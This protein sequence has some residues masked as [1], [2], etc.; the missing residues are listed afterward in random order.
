MS[1]ILVVVRS[2]RF[3]PLEPTYEKFADL[4][5]AAASCPNANGPTFH[6]YLYAFSIDEGAYVNVDHSSYEALPANQPNK[7]L[8]PTPTSVTDRAAHAPRQP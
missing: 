1:L 3:D 5:R 8:E 7:A 2:S 6:F 4:R